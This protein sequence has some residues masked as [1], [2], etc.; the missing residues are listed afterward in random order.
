LLK[1]L[2]L[3]TQ[4]ENIELAFLSAN[5]LK[6]IIKDSTGEKQQAAIYNA[7]GYQT[8]TT[9]EKE[10]YC[11]LSFTSKSLKRR[12]AENFNVGLVH[13]GTSH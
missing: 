6:G 5:R 8:V 10:I 11:L 13:S 1:N 9:E 12:S 7:T 2:K 4:H 3:Y